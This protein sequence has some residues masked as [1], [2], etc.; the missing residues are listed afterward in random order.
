M[1]A[2]STY[3]SEQLLNWNSAIAEALVEPDK[4][5][6]LVKICNGIKATIGNCDVGVFVFHRNSTPS[7]IFD[8]VEDLSTSEYIKF[9]YLLDPIYDRFLKRTLPNTCLMRKTAPDGFFSSEYYEKYYERLNIV[10]EYYFNMPVDEETTFHITFTRMNR[11]QRYTAAEQKL[12]QSHEPMLQLVIEDYWYNFATPLK[13]DAGK[14]QKTHEA[15]TKVFESFGSS[16][17]T[18]RE[19][20][21]MQLMLK[22][23]SDKYTACLLGISPGTVRNHKKSIFVKLKVTSQGQVFGL[24]LEALANPERNQ[25]PDP[26]TNLL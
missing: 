5:K 26:L 8:D 12:L 23:F 21:V 19:Q 24:F 7:C 13:A 6:R 3:S 25:S 9:A 4:V 11:A 17:L 14:N 18:P 2:R 20:E 15:V 10:D 1:S 16:I 22:G